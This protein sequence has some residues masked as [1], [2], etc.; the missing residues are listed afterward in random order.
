MIDSTPTNPSEKEAGPN[1]TVRGYDL[2]DAAKK[3]VEA[4]CPNTV[5]CADIITVATRDAVAL[6]GGPKYNVPTGR[7]DGLVSTDDASLPGPQESVAQAFAEFKAKGFTLNEM[8]TLLGAHTVGVAHCSFFQD[9]LDF[10]GTGRPDPT[11]D[12]ALAARLLKVCG[13]TP[14]S[15]DPTVFLDQ[16]TSFT[17]D[18]QFYNQTI[19]KRGIL[20][21][22]QELARDRST[23]PIVSGFA[24]NGPAWQKS[25]ANAMIK[26]S[27][28]QVLVGKAGDIRKNCRV[29]N[30][31]RGRRV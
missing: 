1:L 26:L 22:D 2:I 18:N 9:R 29:F 20:Q 5:S 4:V 25:F 23:G 21:I 19:F 14:S 31:K 7:R 28:T 3:A 16:G 13:T 6:A 15:R 11:M 12:Q 17:M 10:Q 30:P 24:R 27:K 8:V